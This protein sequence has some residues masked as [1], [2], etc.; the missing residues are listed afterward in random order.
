MIITATL[1][2]FSVSVSRSIRN[3]A[4]QNGVPI[5]TSDIIYRLVDDV[6][7]SLIDMLPRIIETK[8]VGEANVQQLF[9]I[10]L[11]G[12]KT[13]TVAGCRIANGMVEKTKVA[14]VIRGGE[15]VHE[16]LF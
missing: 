11:K 14:R 2:G 15:I 9:E 10:Q 8:V 12:G 13:M 16:G 7:A 1:I 6:R 3:L 4:S 5:F